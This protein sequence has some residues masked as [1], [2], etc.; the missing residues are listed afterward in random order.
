MKIEELVGI[1]LAGV[2][3]VRDYIELYFDGPI[4][5]FLVDPEINQNGVSVNSK[6]IVYKNVLCTLIG[7]NV[8]QLI[9]KTEEHFEVTFNDGTLLTAVKCE[10]TK[11]GEMLH[12][13][14]FL[15]GPISVW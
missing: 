4:L 6:D 8:N 9:F 5:R 12:F 13:V 15:N 3:F 7:K 2:G 10:N 1:E 14:P 11:W